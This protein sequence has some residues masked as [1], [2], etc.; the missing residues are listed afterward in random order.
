MSATRRKTNAASSLHMRMAGKKYQQQ[1]V[2]LKRVDPD[3]RE[4]GIAANVVEPSTARCA[5]SEWYFFESNQN[6]WSK[7]SLRFE[8]LTAML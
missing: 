5:P 1:C 8:I 7:Q 4:N 3:Q 2:K 6:A